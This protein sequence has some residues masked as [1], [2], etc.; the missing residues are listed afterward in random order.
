MSQKSILD[1]IRNNAA[2]INKTIVL[3]EA[4][5]DKRV[6][7][8]A[9]LMAESKLATPILLNIDGDLEVLMKK[10]GVELSE[11]I[12]VYN[13]D[14]SKKYPLLI[15]FLKNK[16]SHKNPTYE[17]ITQMA[18]D[19]LV[20]AGW[21]VAIDKADGAV[22]GSVASTASVIRA[23]LRTIGVTKGTKLVSSIFMMELPDNRVLT[24]GDC[25]VVPYPDAN[26]LAEIAMTSAQSHKLLTGEEAYVAMLSFS[27][28]GSAD[29]ERVDLVR[30][31]LTIVRETDSRLNIDGELQ[32]DTAFVPQ[33]AKRKAPDSEVA[34]K[35][36]VMI[37]PNLDA[38]NIGYKITERVG[39]AKAVGPILQGL[40]KPFMDLSRGCSVDDIVDT[41]CVASVLS[42]TS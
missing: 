13:I 21:L 23:A 28:K 18:S 2:L 41:A 6:F 19:R 25:A 1:K 35:A 26:Q 27:T 12:K 29:H 20:I 15:D 17:Q 40:A 7:L 5:I 16:M 22:A 8:A 30:E 37:F 39:G 4:G 10:M 38:G 31:A 3:P 34:G 24:Y 11:N 33:I 9:N 14:S 32:F 36:N 42:V